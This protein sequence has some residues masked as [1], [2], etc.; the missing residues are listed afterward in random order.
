MK[1]IFETAK[2]IDHLVA[3]VDREII[4]KAHLKPYQGNAKWKASIS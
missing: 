1:D 2:K 4:G 3:Y